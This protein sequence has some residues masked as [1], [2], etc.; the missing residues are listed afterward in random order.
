MLIRP[1]EVHPPRGLWRWLARLPIWLYRARVGWLLG[2][3]FLMLTH[4]GRT[5]GMPRQVALEVV[6][7]DKATGDYYIAAGFGEKSD[8][9]LN[10]GK[11]PRVVVQAGLR[12]W[13]A[14]AAR[15]TPD[16]AGRE[17]LD[18]AH[19]HPFAI[20]ELARMMGYRMDGTEAGY[21]ALG[22]QLPVVALRRSQ[23]EK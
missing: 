17:I 15:L 7:H 18:Y 6:R 13:Q 10:I 11:T 2:D 9:L 5:S 12:Q 8:W 20:R 1:A 14:N 3:R 23:R 4:V 19:R 21:R 16:E 22:R